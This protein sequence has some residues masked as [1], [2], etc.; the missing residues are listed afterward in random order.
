MDKETNNS[1]SNSSIFDFPDISFDESMNKIVKIAV[2]QAGSVIYDTKKSLEKLEFYTQKAA[3]AGAQL[4]L[5]PETFIGGYPKGLDFGVKMGLRNL[6]KRE[7]LKRYFDSSIEYHSKE[8]DFISHI[9][10]RYEIYLVVGVV[11]REGTTL[12]STV[13]FFG[14]DG[15]K[16]GKHR[17]LMPTAF[18]RVVWGRGDGATLPV[19]DTK[20]G[21]I[22]AVICWENF[23]PMLRT[24]MYNKGVQLYL[25]PTVDDRDVWL[26]TVRTVALEGKCFVI[27]ACQYLTT[28]HFPD[29]HTIHQGD[30]QVLISGGSCVINPFGKII[31]KPEYNCEKIEIVECDL[32][33][34]IEAKFD[35]DTVGHYSRPDIFQL[36]VN[37]KQQNPVITEK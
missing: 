15:T 17:K 35:L 16:L 2:V 9:A 29:D 20:I 22:G 32:S 11:E 27:S 14:P 10:H 1:A 24:F 28:K 31:M 4:V 13:F 33:E 30:E 5:F 34:I 19:F 12:F 37:E 6:D 7:D 23:M 3:N 18:E 8:S 21:K 25:T 26:S 36:I